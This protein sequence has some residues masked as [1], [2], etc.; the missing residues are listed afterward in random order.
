M[1]RLYTELRAAAR[2]LMLGLILGWMPSAAA[3]TLPDVELNGLFGNQ[4]VLTISGRQQLL[5]TGQKSPEGVVLVSATLEQ[6]I[7]EFRGDRRILRLS[8]RVTGSYKVR[9]QEVVTLN[10]DRLGQYRAQITI[11]GQPVSCLIDTGASVVA[12]SSAQADRLGIDYLAG[13][14]GQVVTANGRATSY[15]VELP[16]VV[17][18]GITQRN[19]S[20]AVVSGFYPE[21][22]LLGMSFLSALKLEESSGVMSLTQQY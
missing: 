13:R 12:I 7:I 20:A 2:L 9:T 8:Q 22:V 21:E 5:K 10:A 19:V 11:G 18:A 17:L 15:F 4:A 1:S 3:A 6:A 14:E 16:E